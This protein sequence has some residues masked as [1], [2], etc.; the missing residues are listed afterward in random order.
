LVGWV[1]C[2]P[3]V[4]WWRRCQ[5]AGRGRLHGS[6]RARRTTMQPVQ[7]SLLPEQDP[8]PVPQ[9]LGHLPEAETAEAIRL[10]AGLIAKAAAVEEGTGDE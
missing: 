3:R 4:S 8:V 7:L 5:A 6:H 10:L 1:I 9:A 2:W